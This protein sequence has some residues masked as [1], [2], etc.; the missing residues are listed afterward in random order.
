MSKPKAL[1]YGRKVR[2]W[3]S[4]GYVCCISERTYGDYVVSIEKDDDILL[5][6]PKKTVEQAVESAE[7][8]VRFNTKF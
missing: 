8:W 2:L 3:E 6:N 4:S 5:L 1:E 7:T